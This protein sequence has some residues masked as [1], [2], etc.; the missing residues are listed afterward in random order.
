MK[1]KFLLSLALVLAAGQIFSQ[2]TLTPGVQACLENKAPHMKTLLQ[3]A[4]FRFENLSGTA[5]AQTRNNALRLDSTKTFFG[6]NLN[7]T[8]DS[9]PLFRTVLLYPQ[10]N[11]EVELEYQ[12]DFSSWTPVNRYTRKFDAQDRM[13][14]MQTEVFDPVL[15]DYI[16]SS[17]LQFFPRGNSADLVDS[18][19]VQTWSP[20]LNAWETTV[21]SRNVYG[22]QNRLE[23]NTTLI[24]LQGQE[25]VLQDEYFYDTNGDNHLIVSSTLIGGLAFISDK[26]EMS[27]V[28]HLLIQVI[29]Y[30]S[31]GLG[32]F[33]PT[34]RT[35]LAYN[36]AKQVK[37]EN[38]YQWTPG[39]N[40]WAPTETINYEYDNALRLTATEKVFHV[41]GLPDEK[42]RTTVA[43]VEDDKP[44]LET[45]YLWDNT[46]SAYQLD[47]RKYYF[48]AGNVSAVRPQTGKIQALQ[49]S[50]NPTTGL[51]RLAIETEAD[52]HILDA[53]GQILLSRILQPGE[54]LD[55]S[56]LPAGIYQLK[57]RSGKAFFAGKVLKQ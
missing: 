4:G 47:Q 2:K 6:Y 37:Q 35:T 51:L 34:E 55:L 12:F 33:E 27:Y 13:Q 56:N 46:L 15:Q 42:E 43:Y 5:P 10:A 23:L 31:N 40:D 52:V 39:V 49:V 25:F 26:R 36:A 45:T 19:K 7:G 29:A 20:D 11:S 17:L 38:F 24:F 16:P 54:P 50:P 32:F 48:Y 44:A 1:N 9:T 14:E 28:D 8:P 21:H 41:N 57:A 3:K 22:P 18:F 30:N 53:A